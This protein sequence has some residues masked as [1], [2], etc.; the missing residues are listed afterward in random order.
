MTLYS[1][2]DLI[3]YFARLEMLTVAECSDF[4]LSVSHLSVF[5]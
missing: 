4:F 5:G 3:D 2:S 1:S